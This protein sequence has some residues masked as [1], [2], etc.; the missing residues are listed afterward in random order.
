MS[1]S[2]IGAQGLLLLRRAHARKVGC[3]HARHMQVL[4]LEETGKQGLDLLLRH[5]LCLQQQPSLY[6]MHCSTH[7]LTLGKFGNT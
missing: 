2:I 3:Q 5:A 6:T 7:S 4:L 1:T